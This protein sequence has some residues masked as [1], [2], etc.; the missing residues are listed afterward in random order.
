MVISLMGGGW[1]ELGGG[2]SPETATI[3]VYKPDGEPYDYTYVVDNQA[4]YQ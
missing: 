3:D 2:H 1:I 4:G